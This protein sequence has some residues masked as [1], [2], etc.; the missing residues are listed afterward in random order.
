MSE[1]IALARRFEPSAACHDFSSVK[2]WWFEQPMPEA[3][4]SAGSAESSLR[5]FTTQQTPHN[6]PDE[7]FVDDA[8]KVAI[9]Y[10]RAL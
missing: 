1:L 3:V 4:R 6:R 10:P 7:G 5:Y 9:S 2:A 8:A